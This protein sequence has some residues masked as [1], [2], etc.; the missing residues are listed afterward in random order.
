VLSL[1]TLSDAELAQGYE[2]LAALRAELA[3]KRASPKKYA[4]YRLLLAL[5]ADDGPRLQRHLDALRRCVRR[6]D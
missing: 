2:R 5:Y 3:L 1:P 4:L 6:Q